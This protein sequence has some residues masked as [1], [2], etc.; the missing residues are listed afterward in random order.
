MLF[1]VL[2]VGI[3]LM[4]C[5]SVFFL[6]LQFR[7]M[8]ARYLRMESYRRALVYQKQYL[9]LLLG[10][11]QHSVQRVT[12]SLGQGLLM[13]TSSRQDVDGNLLSTPPHWPLDSPPPLVR[14]RAVA[15]CIMVIHRS[16]TLPL[17]NE[18][19]FTAIFFI[20][21]SNVYLNLLLTR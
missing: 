21:L 7:H 19:L 8:S 10:D 15:R 4:F 14:F 6:T 9:L 17:E 20:E 2:F 11:F 1:L 18:F 16:V 13:G 5:F 12:A 3:L